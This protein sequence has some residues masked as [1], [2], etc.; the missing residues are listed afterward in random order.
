MKTVVSLIALVAIGTWAY[1][2]LV[3]TQNRISTQLEIMNKDLEHN[4]EFR[5]KWPR[6]MLGALPADQEQFMMIEDL[7]KSV[8]RLQKA[9]EDGMHNKV[10]IEFLSKQMTKVLNDIEKLKDKQRSFSN[11]N[12]VQ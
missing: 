4:T 2:G 7:Y 1:F 5:I 3:E 8:D 10:N 11:G 6:G 12:G 9:I